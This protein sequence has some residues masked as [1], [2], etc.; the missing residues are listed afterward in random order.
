MAV[1]ADHYI[2]G[3]AAKSYLDESFFDDST[4]KVD[5]VNYELLP[6]LPTDIRSDRELS[7][8]HLLATAGIEETTMLTTFNPA[9]LKIE[10]S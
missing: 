4:I 5:W 6:E 9:P 3:P 2:S 1:G 7:I 8:I 10:K